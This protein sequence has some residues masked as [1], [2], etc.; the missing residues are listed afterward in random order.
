MA[1]SNKRNVDFYHLLTVPPCGETNP[2]CPF[3]TAPKLVET[4]HMQFIFTKGAGKYDKVAVMRADAPAE[5]M[6]SPKQGII[7]HDMV[8]YAV[9]SV[10]H[11]TGF[12]GRVL[13]GEAASYTMASQA[14]SD[15]VERLV[16]VVQAD[17]WAGF[18]SAPADMLALYQVTCDERQCPPLALQAHDI[19]AVRTR[20]LELTSQWQN[21]AVGASMTLAF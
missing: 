8:H 14:Q 1:G 10:L 9:E 21:T 11:V 17:A 4:T 19:D 15:G 7:P 13:E 16:E 12:L 18:N 6:E 5:V 20:I 3:G 2:S